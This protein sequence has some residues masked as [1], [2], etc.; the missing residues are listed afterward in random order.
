MHFTAGLIM[1]K[2]CLAML[3]VTGAI[4]SALRNQIRSHSDFTQLPIKCLAYVHDF[5]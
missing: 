3:P 1:Q 5:T 2:Q 4:C